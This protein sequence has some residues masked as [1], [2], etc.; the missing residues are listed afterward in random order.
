MADPVQQGASIQEYIDWLLAHRGIRSSD[1]SNIIFCDF[2]T[3]LGYSDTGDV[4]PVS[5]TE[6]YQFMKTSGKSQY[7]SNPIGTNNEDAAY[8]VRA[9]T[10]NEK[11]IEMAERI[12]EIESQSNMLQEANVAIAAIAEQTNLLAMNAAIEAAHTGDAGI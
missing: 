6:Y 2:E 5:N 9:K 10:G 4:T 8:Y 7:I 1:F 3:G 12:N 11:Q